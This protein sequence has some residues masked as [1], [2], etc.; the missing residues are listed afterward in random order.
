MNRNRRLAEALGICWHEWKRDWIEDGNSIDEWYVCQKCG[1]KSYHPSQDHPNPDFTADPTL[2][3]VEM[4]KREDWLDF[5]SFVGKFST[6]GVSYDVQYDVSQFVDLIL[7]RSGKLAEMASE[8]LTAQKEGGRD[9][10]IGAKGEREPCGESIE[11][12][13]F[14][15]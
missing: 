8:W 2:V 12:S 3:L 7:D 5:I 10:P 11:G 13:G 1:L 14:R 15:K 9:A 4:R 6:D